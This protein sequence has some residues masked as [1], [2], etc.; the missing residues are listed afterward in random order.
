MV[1]SQLQYWNI[2]LPSVLF[3]LPGVT[4]GRSLPVEMHSLPPTLRHPCEQ[5]TN[6]K[7]LQFLAWGISRFVNRP[8]R[9]KLLLSGFDILQNLH[10]S[11]LDE[12]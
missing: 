3:S 4:A 8:K 10:V 12:Y 2:R 11:Y 9:L 6:F 5:H 7:D 1:P